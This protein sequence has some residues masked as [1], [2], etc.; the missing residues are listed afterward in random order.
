MLAEEI[1]VQMS[2][3]I[4]SFK[5]KELLWGIIKTPETAHNVIVKLILTLK[6]SI[7]FLKNNNIIFYLNNPL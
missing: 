7:S 4:N 3:I 2:K 5:V 1:K 6:S